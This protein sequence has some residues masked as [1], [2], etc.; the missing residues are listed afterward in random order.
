M[1]FEAWSSVCGGPSCAALLCRATLREGDFVTEKPA[2]WIMKDSA[3]D[4]E[5]LRLHALEGVFDEHTCRLLD[6]RIGVQT[7][8][9]YLELGAG[10]GS[11]ARWLADL[12]IT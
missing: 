2:H 9:R 12:G 4:A 3:H 11:I 1:A 10:A 7:G 6:E 8:W 5:L